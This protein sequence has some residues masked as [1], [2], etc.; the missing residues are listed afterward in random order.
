MKWAMVDGIKW[1]TNARFYAKLKTIKFGIVYEF[2]DWKDKQKKNGFWTLHSG[3]VMD[4]Q[5]F[6]LNKGF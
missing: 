2:Y 4:L 1:P 3:I 5:N 6:K